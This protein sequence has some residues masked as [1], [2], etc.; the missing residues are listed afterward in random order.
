MKEQFVIAVQRVLSC[1]EV[2]IDCEN[3]IGFTP[4]Y[5][6][7]T[8]GSEE[9]VELLLKAGACVTVENDDGETVEEM[10]Q[11]KMPHLL[12]SEGLDLAQNRFS[13]DTIENKLFHILQW[14]SYEPGKFQGCW[15]EA[16]K[17]NNRVMVD[18]DNGTYTFLQLCCDQGT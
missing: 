15:E 4:I 12:E 2:N 11:Q 18:A 14:E 6:G 7:V 13:K 3:R 8:N 10:I 16:E 5:F 9:V 1:P 17:N